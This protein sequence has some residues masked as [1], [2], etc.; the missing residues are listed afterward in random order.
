MNVPSFRHYK[1]VDFLCLSNV[2]LES[3]TEYHLQLF[4]NDIAMV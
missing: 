2:S 3:M 1:A 4:F